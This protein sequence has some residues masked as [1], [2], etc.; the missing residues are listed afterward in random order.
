MAVQHPTCLRLRCNHLDLRT[1]RTCRTRNPKWSGYSDR[2]EGVSLQHRI[3][4]FGFWLNNS[5]DHELTILNVSLSHDRCVFL[6]A[7][8]HAHEIS[9]I[10][11]CFG[12]DDNAL[13]IGLKALILGVGDTLVR[14][15]FGPL[16]AATCIHVHRH[17]E[18]YAEGGCELIVREKQRGYFGS[19]WH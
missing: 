13:G 12:I 3:A 7:D 2:Q 5:V 4:E 1:A 14:S 6:R 15:D 8:V 10:D 17:A 11:G 18:R 9:F 16:L 19:V